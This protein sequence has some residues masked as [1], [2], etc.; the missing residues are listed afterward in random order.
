M[1]NTKTDLN[2]AKLAQDMGY[3]VAG[4]VEEIFLGA[5]ILIPELM[6]GH[7]PDYGEVTECYDGLFLTG[8]VIDIAPVHVYEESLDIPEDDEYS[9]MAKHMLSTS[10]HFVVY[11]VL[12]TFDG[13][14]IHKSLGRG[15][16][17]Y[18]RIP[19]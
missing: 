6:W 18:F 13:L 8:T 5:E 17:I 9:G 3:N 15:Y 12:Q 11:F 1:S 10:P 16:E 19:V 7:I 4:W 2:R 14:H